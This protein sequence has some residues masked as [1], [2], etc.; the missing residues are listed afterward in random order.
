MEGLHSSLSIIQ[1]CLMEALSVSED[2]SFL[3]VCQQ[4]PRQPGYQ[5]DFSNYRMSSHTLGHLTPSQA[6]LNPLVH[7]HDSLMT[8]STDLI[9]MADLFLLNQ[10]ILGASSPQIRTEILNHPYAFPDP[11]HIDQGLRLLQDFYKTSA[12]HPIV[13]LVAFVQGMLSLHPFSD[14]NHRTC[15][16]I[17]DTSLCQMNY[18][19]TTVLKTSDL[20]FANPV[21]QK[22]FSLSFALQ[23]VL[24]GMGETLSASML[25]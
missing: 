25:E 16:L 2:P 23:A 22:I 6:D 11:E 21:E 1:N 18:P 9:E 15:R 24:H 19:P 12:A 4:I 3:Q 14:G 10:M 20:I 7:A 17:L 5:I 13:K 8:G